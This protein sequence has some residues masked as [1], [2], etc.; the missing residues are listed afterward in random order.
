[1]GLFLYQEFEISFLPHAA[2]HSAGTMGLPNGSRSSTETQPG[3][4][5]HPPSQ[6]NR[7]QAQVAPMR[8]TSEPNRHELQASRT[9]NHCGGMSVLGGFVASFVACLSPQ[10]I[11]I[12]VVKRFQN[13]APVM[14]VK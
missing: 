10:L 11:P 1:M 8:F 5:G 14:D 2:S 6:F 9:A 7:A 3:G 4:E 12:L 13:S